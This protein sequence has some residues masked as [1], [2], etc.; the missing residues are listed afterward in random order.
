[1]LDHRRLVMKLSRP[2]PVLKH[3]ARLLS[4]KLSIPLHAAL[5]RV[6]REEGF[7]TWSHLTAHA[8]GRDRAR[9][10]FTQLE[11]GDL[12]LL[13]SRPGQG[14]TTL[15][16][17]LV[18]EA[19]MAGHA[20]AF[21]TL[22]FTEEDV[23]TRLG[24]MQV[25]EGV[26]RGRLRIDASEEITAAYIMSELAES[27]RGT[28]VIVDYLQL[29][30]QRRRSPDLVDQV[31]SLKAFTRQR[32]LITVCLSQVDRS[33]ERSSRAL[34]TLSDVRLPNPLDLRLFTKACFLHEGGMRL[35]RVG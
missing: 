30:D 33:F 1:V 14:K 29:L 26:A 21:F 35:D 6:A 24:A 2:V 7:R 34:P 11:P 18:A 17:E 13:A 32:G 25:N 9:D 4:R 15:G 16:L 10:L 8:P 12:I 20:T 3:R 31:R 28:L 5:D 27:D 23:R 19:A 22:E